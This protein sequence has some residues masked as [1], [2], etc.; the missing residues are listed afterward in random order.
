[1]TW[2]QRFSALAELDGD[3]WD[4]EHER[5]EREWLA[6]YI[7]AFV[8]FAVSRGWREANAETWPPEI[9]DEAFIEAYRYDWDPQQAAEADVVGCE[10]ERC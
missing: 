6:A 4:A 2:E 8:K 5:L 3:E 1:M 10:Q 7:A 9:G